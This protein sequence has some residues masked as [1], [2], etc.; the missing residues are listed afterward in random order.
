MTRT[1][2]WLAFSVAVAGIWFAVTG[3]SP[4]R[5]IAEAI[6]A[7]LRVSAMVGG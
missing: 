2:T 5:L 1:I 4:L 7:G 3:E 6:G